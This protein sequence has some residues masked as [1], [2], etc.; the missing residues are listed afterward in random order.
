MQRILRPA[1]HRR[2]QEFS[3]LQYLEPRESN[4]SADTAFF[5][6]DSVVIMAWNGEGVAEGASTGKRRIAVAERVSINLRFLHV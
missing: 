1:E 6:H 3:Y 5:K 4:Q 2:K